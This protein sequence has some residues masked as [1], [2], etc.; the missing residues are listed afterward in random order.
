MSV[1]EQ[2]L[3]TQQLGGVNKPHDPNCGCQV[4]LDIC[5]RQAKAGGPIPVNSEWWKT[6]TV[7]PVDAAMRDGVKCKLCGGNGRVVRQFQS[8]IYK[9]GFVTRALTCDVC[10]GVGYLVPGPEYGGGR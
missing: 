4:C 1:C 7:F 10:L 6:Q 3:P 8:S 9:C 5:T 2:S